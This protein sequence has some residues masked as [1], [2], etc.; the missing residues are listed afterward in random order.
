MWRE[1]P[2]VHLLK[3]PSFTIK[4]LLCVGAT[5]LLRYVIVRQVRVALVG[6]SWDRLGR[7]GKKDGTS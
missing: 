7:P 4:L 5:L 1:R 6:T 2:G 3:P